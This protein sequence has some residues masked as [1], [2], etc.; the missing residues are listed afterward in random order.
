MKDIVG[1]HCHNTGEYRGSAHSV[2][3]LNSNVSKEF[4]K[5]NINTEMKITNL[6]LVELSISI[7][8]VFLNTQF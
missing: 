7:A 3:N 1:D 5:S 6:K 2:C 4:I 8:N